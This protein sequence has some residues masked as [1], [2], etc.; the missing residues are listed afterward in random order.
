MLYIMLA[1]AAAALVAWALTHFIAKA[2]YTK[3]IARLEGELKSEQSLREHESQVYDKTLA[4]L[5]ENQ[6]AV[7]EATK[8]ELA[9]ENEKRMKAREESIKKEAA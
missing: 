7:I 8:N 3:E 2:N 4:E 6:K 1:A 9:L 5:K